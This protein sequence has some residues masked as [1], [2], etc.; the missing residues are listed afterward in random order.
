[1]IRRALALLVCSAL[2][3]AVPAAPTAADP[4]PVNG[5]EA[6]AVATLDRVEELAGD[7]TLALR[8]LAQLKDALPAEL[9]QRAASY[10]S[11]PTGN[12]SRCADFS[13]YTTR[14]VRRVCTTLLCVH[15]VERADDRTNG[16]PT[17][18]RDD[19]GR[20][21]YV[22]SVLAS[23]VRVH[24]T[25][26]DAGY[27][28]PLGD[29]TR[30]GD[31]RPDVYLAQIGDQALYG[32]CATDA[33]AVPQH[34]ATWAYC[35]L[36]NDYRKSE[37]PLHTPIQN[38][39]VTAAH[40]YFH[41]VQFGYD[42]GEDAWFMEA[43][44]TWVEDEVFDRVDDNVSYLSW[45]PLGQPDLPLDSL[46][47][48]Y[49]YGA[50]I[51]FRHLTERFRTSHA[52][53][54]E[55]VRTTWRYADAARPGAPDHYS[56]AAVDRALADQGSSVADQFLRMSAANQHPTRW[57]AEGRRYPRAPLAGTWWLTR[58]DPVAEIRL[59]QDHLTSDTYR[60]EPASGM[61][62][63]DWRLRL[64]LDLAP[65]RRGSQALAR[66]F[67]KTGGVRSVV[68]DLSETGD[69]DGTVA[70]SATDVTAVELTVVNASTRYRCGFGTRWSCHGRPLDQDVAQR[71]VARAERS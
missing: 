57:Y 24:R 53:L 37:F 25:Y 69:Y 52:G 18:D 19:D 38:M 17:R 36:D 30:G 7:R 59:V 26:V 13:C 48:G 65:E 64:T 66:V 51:F 45:G 21:D 49:Y 27:R 60:F 4:V 63:A 23:M 28:R 39:Q 40:E 29:G 55:I 43:T 67:L 42:V 35:V 68:L 32:Y 1:M 16:V 50:W 47:D 3:T 15:Y 70:F 31:A 8:D 46:Q 54:P 2:V 14:E 11:R 9:Q 33:A 71:V 62:A 44:A 20:P 6:R 58:T 34:G 22:E 12:P 61:A 56:L 5:R 41:A 10:L